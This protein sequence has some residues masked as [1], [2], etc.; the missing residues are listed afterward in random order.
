MLTVA[1][2]AKVNLVIDGHSATNGAK[3]PAGSKVVVTSN[4]GT[5]ATADPVPDVAADTAE[6]VVPI[7][8]VGPGATDISADIVAPDGTPFHASDSLVVTPP[9][10]PGITH[11]TATLVSA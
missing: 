11:I 1:L 10:E 2:G 9:V 4:D 3:I 8:V 6:I 5:V 7:T